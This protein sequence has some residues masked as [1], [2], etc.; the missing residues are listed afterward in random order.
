MF[1]TL[2]HVVLAFLLLLVLPARAQ[3]APPPAACE[4]GED[5]TA[6]DFWVGE[7]QVYT[8]DEKQTPLGTNSVTK[9]YG[10]CLI[11][12]RWQG[13]DGSAGA[14]INYYNNVTDEWR[15]VWISNGYSIDVA[16]GLD[17]SGAMVL[18]GFI[19]NYQQAAKTP[20]RGI[21]T[22][23]EDG[24]VIQHFDIYNAD[25]EDWNVWFEGRY[26]REDSDS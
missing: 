16:G 3:N 20:F 25:D 15:Q 8:N 9:H 26:V 2:Q 12:E 19:Y 5:F 1:R 14:S 21:W 22:P 17:A 24:S 23:N 11:M 18:E 4:S 13:A 7:W 6:F 10:D